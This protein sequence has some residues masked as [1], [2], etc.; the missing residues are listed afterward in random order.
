MIRGG[1]NRCS[2]RAATPITFHSRRE[3]HQAQLLA[4]SNTARRSS[5]QLVSFCIRCFG[6]IFR[7]GPAHIVPFGSITIT[8]RPP[9]SL[10]HLGR[11]AL[12]LVSDA[13]HR[14]DCRSPSI[15]MQAIINTNPRS[16]M[17]SIGFIMC[18]SVIGAAARPQA[19]K[20]LALVPSRLI[21]QLAALISGKSRPLE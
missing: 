7:T 18:S 12:Q 19:G 6:T 2:H 21:N 8:Q 17:T 11:G 1:R 14:H 4:I 10:H 20:T 16:G 13:Y 5:G 3:G 15:G 9:N